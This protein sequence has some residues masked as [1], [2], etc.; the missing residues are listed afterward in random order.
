MAPAAEMAAVGV[1]RTDLGVK[2]FKG[3]SIEIRWWFPKIRGI[4]F[5]R[6]P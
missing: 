5:G 2:A 4:V 3:P 1:R 6:S